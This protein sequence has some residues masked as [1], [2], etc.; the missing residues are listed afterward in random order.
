M[1]YTGRALAIMLMACTSHAMRVGPSDSISAKV[2]MPR[3]DGVIVMQHSAESAVPSKKQHR[4]RSPTAEEAQAKNPKGLQT[5]AKYIGIKEGDRDTKK[6]L[7]RKIMGRDS[8]KRGGTPFDLGIHK[9]VSQKM[10]E[11][12]AGELVEELK[13]SDLRELNAGE[14]NSRVTFLL[15]KEF[16]FCWGVERSIELAWAAREAYPGKRM[17]ITNELIHNPGVNELLEGMGIQFMEKDEDAAGGK[18][19]DAVQ[20]GDVRLLPQRGL[21]HS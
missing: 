14:G 2:T 11:R 5:A 18:R 1:L 6:N 12:F 4:V 10:S 9:E 7:R 16:G 13:Q 20:N 19:F 17:H 3:L 15:A 21:R 8:Y